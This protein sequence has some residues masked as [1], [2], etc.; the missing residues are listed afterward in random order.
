[1][2]TNAM[3]KSLINLQPRT[4]S[5]LGSGI[6]R[7]DY[8]ANI[9]KSIADKVPKVYD[10]PKL[11]KIFLSNIK[12]ENEN[13]NSNVLSPCNVVLMQELER[14][15]K[16]VLK[17]S[18]SL[19]DLQRA[20]IGEIGMSNELDQLSNSLFNGY[21]PNLWR[22]YAPKTEKK[23]G[24]W[25]NHFTRRYK[26]YNDWIEKKNPPNVIWLAGLHIP[27]TYLAALVQTTCRKNKWPL[28]KS[29]LF[30]KVTNIKD[31]KQIDKIIE[32]NL[33]NGIDDDGC[34]VNGL[35]LE[36]AGWDYTNS[37]LIKQQAKK[38]IYELPIVKIIPMELNKVKRQKTFSTP[39]YV[40]QQRRNAMGV[41]LV[42]MADLA[43]DKHPSHWILQ[44]TALTLNK[45]E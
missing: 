9:A 19:N 16:L 20:L 35:Y 15:N 13:K 3:W 23:L 1:M 2:A 38:L 39:V 29:T 41:G 10:I 5:N 37:C 6:R 18:S 30:T 14:W 26:Q 27:E 21:L 36:G 4:S 28:D 33:S 32:N 7:E 17:M 25:I 12:D 8:I 42:F 24:T 43:T 11:K 34:Y 44:G 31:I 40:T 22:K 45:S